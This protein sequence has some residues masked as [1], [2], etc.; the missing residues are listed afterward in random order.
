MTVSVNTQRLLDQFVELVKI[1]SPSRQEG[2]FAEYMRQKLADIGFTVETDSA[3]E[4]INGDS[5]NIIATLPGTKSAA[6]LMFCCHMDTVHPCKDIQPIVEDDVIHT[7]GTTIL[8]G[9]DKGG[10]AA[11]LEA[12][13]Q[14]KEQEIA[15]GP[16]QVVLTI[17]EEI[18]MYGSKNLDYS[19]IKAKKAFILDADGPLG[20]IVV[21][22]PAKN[23]IKATIHG[24]AAHAGM[25]PEQGINAIQVA[26]RAIDNMKLLRIDADTT[27]NLGTINGGTATNIVTDQVDIV[28][29]ARSLSNDKL[30]AQSQHMKACFEQAAH[31]FGATVDVKIE[32]SYSAFHLAADDSVILQCIAAMQSLDLKPNLVSTGGGS[33]CNVFN[34]QGISAVDIAIGMTDVH[35]KEESIKISDLKT[36]TRLI[37]EIIKHN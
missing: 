36:A 1:S 6:V 30:A 32:R 20:N 24:K 21:Q 4:A 15:H 8:S 23:V 29:E 13:R 27:A 10:I 37:I 19:K 18:G 2:A 12:I 7:D 17:G 25:Y 5:G 9:D 33:D 28:A 11:I 26:A 14:V 22:G 3:G 35:T 16:I 31:E 34:A